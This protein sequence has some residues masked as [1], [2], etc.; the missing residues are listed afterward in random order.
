MFRFDFDKFAKV[1]LKEVGN[2]L[3]KQGKENMDEVSFGRVYVV[4][5]KTH[6]ASKAGDTANNL[7][8]DLKKSIRFKIQG[9]ILEYGAGNT[10]VNYAKYLEKGTK[11]MAVRPNYTKSILQ[12][13]SKIDKVIKGAL[14]NSLKVVK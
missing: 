3:V 13:K 12:N 1:A 7:S 9:N 8:G 14:L 4:G 10:K 6:I 11:R 5:G 2:V